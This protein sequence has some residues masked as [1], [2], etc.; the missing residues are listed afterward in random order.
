MITV[1]VYTIARPPAL[2]GGQPIIKF[3]IK[4]FG[5][6]KGCKLWHE[7]LQEEVPEFKDKRDELQFLEQ[8]F[9]ENEFFPG[10]VTQVERTWFL[11]CNRYFK[12]K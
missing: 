2:Q 3:H 4:F 6:K 12:R 5:H 1:K 10:P 7:K 9:A 11:P 8:F